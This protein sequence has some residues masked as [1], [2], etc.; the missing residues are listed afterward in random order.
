MTKTFAI[1]MNKEH[2]SQSLQTYLRTYG[3]LAGDDDYFDV[4]TVTFLKDGMVEVK[5]NVNNG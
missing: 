1:T 4:S 5:G 3:Y 2:L